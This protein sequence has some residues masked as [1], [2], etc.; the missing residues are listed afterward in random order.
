MEKQFTDQ[1]MTVHAMLPCPLC[2]GRGGK[3]CE[4]CAGEKR[5]A[6][7]ALAEYDIRCGTPAP[8]GSKLPPELTRL[9]VLRFAIDVTDNASNNEDIAEFILDRWED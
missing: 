2:L 8:D 1:L 7:I 9:R 5:I 6:Q 4:V 3:E